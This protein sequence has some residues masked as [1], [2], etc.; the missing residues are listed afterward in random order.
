MDIVVWGL[1]FLLL[2]VGLVGS[3]VP[4]MPGTTLILLGA[5]LQKLLLSPTITWLA[6]GWIAVFWLFSVV[7]DIACTV[8]G[9]RLLGG[10]KWGMAG[11]SGGALAGVF[12]SLPALLLGT[13]FGAVAAEKLGAKRTHGDALKSGF[14]AA[15]GFLAS[16]FVRGACALTMVAIYAAAVWPVA[17]ALPALP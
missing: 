7:A 8:V 15:L 2:L 10:S 6:V 1:V 12:F 16:T 13:I 14:G 9:S 5:L 17:A 4:L 3:V 11:A